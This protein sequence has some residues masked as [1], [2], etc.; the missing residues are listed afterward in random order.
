MQPSTLYAS[1]EEEDFYKP[2]SLSLNEITF[3]DIP[4]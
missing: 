1:E 4:F 3:E 2:L